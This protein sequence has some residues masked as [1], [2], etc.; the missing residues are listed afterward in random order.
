MD[1]KELTATLE[2]ECGVLCWQELE[3]HFARG[4]V[5]VIAANTK[6]IDIAIDIAQNNTD[7]ISKAL[8]EKNIAE[9]TDTQAVIWQQQNANFLCVV[10]AP[11][12]LIQE[13][14]SSKTE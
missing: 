1:I 6:L 11:Y 8:S 4:A 10:V 12:V 5:R 13:S 7:N 3:K 2:S 14:D 9:A